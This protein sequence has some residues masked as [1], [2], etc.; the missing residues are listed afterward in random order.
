MHPHK[1]LIVLVRVYLKSDTLEVKTDPDPI[2]ILDCVMALNPAVVPLGP[3]AKLAR[4][5]IYAMT[6]STEF[7]NELPPAIAQHVADWLSRTE[8]V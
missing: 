8:T 2:A 7:L 6:G 1:R 5:I 3:L 4:Y